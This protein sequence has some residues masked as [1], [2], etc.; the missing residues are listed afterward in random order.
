MCLL[1]QTGIE[2]MSETIMPGGKRENPDYRQ[3]AG[4]IPNATYMRFKIACTLLDMKMTEAIEE[5][6]N[7][8]LEK[9]SQQQ[10]EK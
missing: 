5:A 6:I 1:L 8:W 4:Y 9:H 3:V 10:P 2:V 7:D